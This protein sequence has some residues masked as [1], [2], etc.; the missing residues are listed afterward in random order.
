MERSLKEEIIETTSK[1]KPYVKP[2][3]EQVQLLVDEAVLGTGCKS[4]S[5]NG[6]RT[7]CQGGPLECD[8]AGS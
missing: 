2:V 1:R 4:T 3:I 6:Y 5:I 8:I 7:P